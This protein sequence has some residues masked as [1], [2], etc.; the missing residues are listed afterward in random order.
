[1][2]NNCNRGKH[3][4]CGRKGSTHHASEFLYQLKC[5]VRPNNLR[6]VY[7]GEQLWPWQQWYKTVRQS[8]RWL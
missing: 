4:I 8:D 1:M 7:L 6:D 3:K 2:T 5:N